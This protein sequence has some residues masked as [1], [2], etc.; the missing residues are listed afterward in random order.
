MNP[1]ETNYELED[2]YIF[3]VIDYLSRP[4]LQPYEMNTGYGLKP[5]IYI[6]SRKSEFILSVLGKYFDSENIAYRVDGKKKQILI[7]N[8][9][10]ILKLGQLGRGSYIQIADRLRYICSFIQEFE[11]KPISGHKQRFLQVYQPWTEMNEQWGTNKKYTLEFFKKQ[12]GV[13][14]IEDT[15]ETP[16]PKFPEEISTEYVAGAFD[17]T[18]S[19]T[20]HIAKEPVNT[21]GYTMAP[22]ANIMIPNPKILIKPHFLQYFEKQGLSPNISTSDGRLDIQ[23]TSAD[24]V[25][26]FLETVGPHVFRHFELCQLFYEKLIPAYRDQ[27]HTTK[28][29]FYDMV[30]AYERVI[31]ERSENSKYTTEYFEQHW[32][33]DN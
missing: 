15:F 22:T 9:D 19:L 1:P 14:M 13:D 26:K 8:K 32:E 3:G 5:Q 11:G 27:Y 28:E 10:S 16:D 2:Q 21:T 24:S 12:F 18:G 7:E 31:G 29:G 17:S 25:E 33:L 6:S 30:R 4:N 23:F 20:L